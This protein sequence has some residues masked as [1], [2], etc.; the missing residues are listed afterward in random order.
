MIDFAEMLLC[1]HQ[2]VWVISSPS[3]WSSCFEIWRKLR[4]V[5][6]LPNY[7]LHFRVAGSGAW[8]EEESSPSV[9]SHRIPGPKA[10]KS[11]NSSSLYSSSRGMCVSSSISRPGDSSLSRPILPP[12]QRRRFRL[13]VLAAPVPRRRL[14]SASFLAAATMRLQLQT[15]PIQKNFLYGRNRN[16][17]YYS[18]RK[19]GTGV[20][21]PYHISFEF[22]LDD[23]HLVFF[24]L[25]CIFRSALKSF[26]Y[27]A[28]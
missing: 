6:P 24:L 27:V 28:I 19:I 26:H 7:F 23:L 17:E 15:S 20:S 3:I 12:L 18:C 21:S 11:P 8:K 1:L 14:C 10:K 16:R 22:D 25:V 5:N 4:L 2:W 9:P 13:R